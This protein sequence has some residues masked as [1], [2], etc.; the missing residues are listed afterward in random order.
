MIYD[1]LVATIGSE[2]RLNGLG[3]CAAG[4]DVANNSSIFGVVAVVRWLVVP[5]MQLLVT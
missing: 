5:M 3:D 2:R 4:V 1:N